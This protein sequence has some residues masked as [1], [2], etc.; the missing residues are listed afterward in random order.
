MPTEVEANVEA[1]RVTVKGPKG[2]LSQTFNP[3]LTI[4][5]K[6]STITVSRPSEEDKLKALH[7][8]TRTLIANMVQGVSKGYQKSLQIVGVGYRVLKAG[9]KL[10]F[11]VGASHPLEVT[12]LPNIQ[13]VVEGT[14]RIHVQGID[15]QLVGQVAAH[16]RALRPPDTYKGK[17][18]RYVGEQVKLKPGKSA[19]KKKE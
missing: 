6:D 7:G 13:F 8:L 17:G 12:P 5:I 3:N 10:V 2:Q 19:A 18:I 16:I 4:Q 9:D 14:N 1:N 11:Q 15:K